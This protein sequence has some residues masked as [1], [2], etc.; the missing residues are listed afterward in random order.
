MARKRSGIIRHPTPSNGSTCSAPRPRVPSRRSSWRC[1]SQRAR[2]TGNTPS[3]PSIPSTPSTR[4]SRMPRNVPSN[5]H[6]GHDGHKGHDGHNGQSTWSTRINDA[7]R[8][9][10]ERGHIVIVGASLAGLSAAE[11]LRAEGFTGTLTIIGDEPYLPYDRPPLSKAVLSAW[12]PAEHTQL[13]RHE[14]LP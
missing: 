2:S 7:L 10:T 3:I 14:T 11:T 13:P 6:D 5:G 4:R 1:R 12:F 9:F 8:A